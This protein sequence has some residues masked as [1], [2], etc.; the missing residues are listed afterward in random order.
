[1]S[2]KL[3]A[4]ST[5][6]TPYKGVGR[7]SMDQLMQTELAVETIVLT[8]S[9]ELANKVKA[10]ININP[11]THAVTF[12][13]EKGKQPASSIEKL[14]EMLIN[15]GLEPIDQNISMQVAQALDKNYKP[16]FLKHKV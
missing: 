2:W 15:E 7:A 4:I 1:M 11:L 5:P 3:E 16:Q 14:N 13:T 8:N 12:V 6:P 10:T 9:E